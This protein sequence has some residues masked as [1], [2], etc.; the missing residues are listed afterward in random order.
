MAVQG[1]ELAQHALILRVA[2]AAGVANLTAASAVALV[3]QHALEQVG[4][5]HMPLALQFC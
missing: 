4:C 1:A 5:V 3:E 2:R